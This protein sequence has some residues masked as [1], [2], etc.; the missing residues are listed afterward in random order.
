MQVKKFFTALQM[1]FYRFCIFGR[2]TIR[3]KFNTITF[4]GLHEIFMSRRE[5]HGFYKQIHRRRV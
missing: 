4:I 3:V 2:N 1:A 5:M